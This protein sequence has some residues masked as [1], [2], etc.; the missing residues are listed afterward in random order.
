MEN[1]TDFEL[2][3]KNS[4]ALNARSTPNAI[5]AAVFD[6]ADVLDCYVIDNP[7][8]N[9]VNTGA[10]NYPVA[11]HSVYVAAVGGLDADVAAAIWSK[12]DVGCDYNGNTSVTVTD[13]SGYNYPQ[14]SYTVKFERPSA[15]PCKFAV[16]LVND[17]LLP[18]NIV[19]LVK[20]A[21]IARFNGTDGT[22]RERI[23]SIILASRYYGAVTA[24]APNVA[25]LSVLIG[26]VTPTLTQVAV[27]IDQRPTLSASDISVTLV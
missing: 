9:T 10:T 8:N 4:V 25:L 12:K 18:L 24:C 21:V 6:V 17:P 11:P 20:T 27:G 14:P 15:L 23:G 19:D 16:Q 13:A 3:R 7:T 5:Y 2:R 26:T 22:V 1:R